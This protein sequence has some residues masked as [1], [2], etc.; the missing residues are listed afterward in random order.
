MI[1]YRYVTIEQALADYE[2][3]WISVCSGDDKC[4]SIKLEIV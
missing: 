3:G 4:A 2:N 1:N